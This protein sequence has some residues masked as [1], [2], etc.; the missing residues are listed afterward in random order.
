MRLNSF[1][2][3]TNC[4]NPAFELL[5]GQVHMWVGGHMADM[6][7]S[8]ND[9]IFYSHHAFVDYQWEMWRQTN[10]RYRQREEEYVADSDACGSFH[11]GDAHMLPFAKMKNIDGLANSYTDEFYQYE[12]RPVCRLTNGD[13]R[14]PYLFCYEGGRCLSKVQL[15]GNCAGLD[16]FDSCYN[17]MCRDGICI[18]HGEDNAS[19]K[20]LA[21]NV[22]NEES[23][24][25]FVTTST[26][27]NTP[28]QSTIRH[29]TETIPQGFPNPFPD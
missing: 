14:S 8:A 6:P 24:R 26:E 27:T 23:P 2:Q 7:I 28:Q 11:H 15:G 12:P 1:G 25:V 20:F 18:S 29:T 17:S 4:L 3:F 10:Q 9:P 5:H 13:C 19:H 22:R 21:D 16:A